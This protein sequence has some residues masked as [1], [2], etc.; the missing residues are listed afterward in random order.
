MRHLS[1]AV[2]KVVILCDIVKLIGEFL[3]SFYNKLNVI[4]TN[5]HPDCK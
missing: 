5:N 1:D 4:L 2:K 3:E